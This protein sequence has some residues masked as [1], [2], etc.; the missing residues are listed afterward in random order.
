MEKKSLGLAIISYLL[1]HNFTTVV[2]VEV[3]HTA[4]VRKSKH[5]I[6]L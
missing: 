3:S 1:G 4:V 6:L 5:Q 2:G